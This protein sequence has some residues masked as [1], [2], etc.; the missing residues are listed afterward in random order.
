M[1]PFSRSPE[2]GPPPQEIEQAPEKKAEQFLSSQN[3]IKYAPGTEITSP[4]SEKYKISIVDVE[5]R[6][7][8]LNDKEGNMYYY[9]PADL[10]DWER[11]LMPNELDGLHFFHKTEG[12]VASVLE[13]DVEN[14]SLKMIT[15]DHK[16]FEIPFK[17][18][19]EEYIEAP[20]D[21]YAPFENSVIEDAET[22]QPIHIERI[23]IPDG[24]AVIE[25]CE[26]IFDKR[27]GNMIG[28][29]GVPSTAREVPISEFDKKFKKYSDT[30][31]YIY[32]ELPDFVEMSM[33]I[34]G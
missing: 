33:T 4:K 25:D 3:F 10:K 22:S 5:N 34:E 12:W 17:Q 13:T 23:S 20:D 15:Q 2:M 7:I 6:M 27:T 24:I 1:W 26:R 11:Q 18:L 9:E 32:G 21:V 16:R 14:N 30:V 31:K 28:I 8:C 29:K 19:L